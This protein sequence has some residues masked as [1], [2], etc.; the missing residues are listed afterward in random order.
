MA[1]AWAGAA[2]GLPGR[3]IGGRGLF[4]RPTPP[5]GRGCR[6]GGRAAPG[7][8]PPPPPRP[9]RGAVTRGGRVGWVF[10]HGDQQLFAGTLREDVAFGPR[11]LGYA[12]A[13][14]SRLPA[15]GLDLPDLPP[16]GDEPPYDLPPP[17]RKL[18]AL[19][20]ALA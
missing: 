2:R 17:F 20:G 16:F 5:A 4:A 8:A 12:P 6:A 13:H 11:K 7:G 14:C 10:Q 19:A 9:G 1:G 3:G 15:Y 18:A